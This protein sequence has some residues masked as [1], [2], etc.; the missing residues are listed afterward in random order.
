[1]LIED[2]A[3][4]FD[5]DRKLNFLVSTIMQYMFELPGHPAS[6]LTYIR[7]AINAGNPDCI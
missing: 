1:M 5:N 2:W 3:F 7:V 4:I 6:N